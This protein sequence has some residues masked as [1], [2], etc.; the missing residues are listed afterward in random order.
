MTPSVSYLTSLF[1]HILMQRIW[2][3]RLDWDHDLPAEIKR[4]FWHWVDQLQDLAAVSVPRWYAVDL[5]TWLQWKRELNVLCDASEKAFRLVTY[6]RCTSKTGRTEDL[7]ASLATFI[8]KATGEL[9]TIIGLTRWF[10]FLGFKATPAAGSSTW[11]TIY[12]TPSKSQHL[13]SGSLLLGK[14]IQLIYAREKRLPRSCLNRI[15]CGGEDIL[16]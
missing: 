6:L 16:G 10:R 1:T 9:K 13:K 3:R 12:S 4:E 15:L 2:R 7:A 5:V 11:P 8:K 14:K